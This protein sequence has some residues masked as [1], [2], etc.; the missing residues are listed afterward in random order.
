MLA[1]TLAVGVVAVVAVYWASRVA[2]GTGA[3]LRTAVFTRVQGFSA[4]EV[5][6]FGTPS[7]I[8]RNTN[9]IQQI[10]L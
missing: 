6:R 8:T 4:R 1:I 3:D 2:M 7:L 10:Q 9:D 5:N